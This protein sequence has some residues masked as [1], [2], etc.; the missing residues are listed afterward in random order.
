MT[1]SS[2]TSPWPSGAWLA[3][4]DAPRLK[5]SPSGTAWHSVAQRGATSV[6]RTLS[7]SNKRQKGG[8]TIPFFFSA[9]KERQPVYG[10]IGLYNDRRMKAN[11]EWGKMQKRKWRVKVTSEGGI[12][13]WN[14]SF[15]CSQTLTLPL[16]VRIRLVL[17][18]WNAETLLKTL[19]CNILQKFSV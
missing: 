9:G 7:F 4:R 13:A 18:G 12:F 8:R 3:Q 10:L 15:D 17:C 14:R 6:G 1:F 2:S 16:Y 5:L 19:S 11:L